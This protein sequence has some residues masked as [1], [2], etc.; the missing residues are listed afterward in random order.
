MVGC[1]QVFNTSNINS[2]YAAQLEEHR[3]WVRIPAYSFFNMAI[4][5]LVRNKL[6]F[7]G[8]ELSIFETVD[9]L[10]VLSLITLILQETHIQSLISSIYELKFLCKEVIE[11]ILLLQREVAVLNDLI[12]RKSSQGNMLIDPSTL[13][14]L[15]SC[16]I[17]I[18]VV[19]V[20]TD[21][22]VSLLG[23]LFST[24]F[25][26]LFQSKGLTYIF[27]D[28][29]TMLDWALI[30]AEDSSLQFYV[31]TFTATTYKPVGHYFLLLH[32]HFLQTINPSYP[33]CT[34]E[35]FA[36]IITDIA[37]KL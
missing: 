24:S 34:M 31:K 16:T 25:T 7:I 15:V 37:S 23:K 28:E 6:R 17:F 35:D 4:Q 14:F 2:E 29:A 21:A 13:K 3:F 30:V 11:Q 33:K 26:N 9:L 22:C 27:R 5:Q 8:S 1:F 19:F 18:L 36:N 20:N 10:L 12:Q 32:K